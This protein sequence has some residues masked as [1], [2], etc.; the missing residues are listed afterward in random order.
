MLAMLGS[1]QDSKGSNEMERLSQMIY[2]LNSKESV[3]LKETSGAQQLD[4]Y[5]FIISIIFD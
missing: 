4:V 1:R 3:Q 5:S 2:R